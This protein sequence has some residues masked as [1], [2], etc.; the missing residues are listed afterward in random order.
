M[1]SLIV[2][3]LILA[4]CPLLG[5]PCDTDAKIPANAEVKKTGLLN[6]GS[7]DLSDFSATV[8]G[9]QVVYVKVENANILGAAV[10]VKISS[11]GQPCSTALVIGPKKTQV[12]SY[13]VLSDSTVTYDVSV[14]PSE[15]A[16]VI[17]NITVLTLPVA[18][19]K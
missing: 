18:K 8:K 7:G 3:A 1:R 17:A 4:A 16:E 12:F 11:G 9:G 14:G 13:G 5:G 10:V 2:A 6:T 19:K 15:G